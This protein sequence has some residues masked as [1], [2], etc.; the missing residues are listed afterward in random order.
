MNRQDFDT[1]LFTGEKGENVVDKAP[2]GPRISDK[3]FL[4]YVRIKIEHTVIFAV[5]FLLVVVLFFAFGVERGK[6]ISKEK[7][8]P[9]D[10]VEESIVVLDE[11][12]DLGVELF[13]AMDTD[14]DP[15]GTEGAQDG[16]E[17]SGQV[18]DLAIAEIKE[19]IS[20]EEIVQE[21]SEPFSEPEREY[22]LYLISFQS[23]ESAEGEVETLKS[24]GIDAAFHRSGSWYQVYVKGNS[25]IEK[26]EEIKTGFI[27]RYPDS[28]IRRKK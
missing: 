13:S 9:F 24:E 7:S 5:V 22:W 23:E 11:E 18:E 26:A 2:S 8:V 6:G 19:Q 3:R 28:F 27:E 12:S 4:P 14:S 17:L 20:Q 21:V 16:T 25:N 1:D 10:T 15:A